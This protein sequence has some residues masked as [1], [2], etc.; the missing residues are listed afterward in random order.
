MNQSSL[1]TTPKKRRNCQRNDENDSG[2]TPRLHCPYT[3]GHSRRKLPFGSYLVLEASSRES[4]YMDPFLVVPLTSTTP[5]FIPQTPS[6]HPHHPRPAPATVLRITYP[7]SHHLHSSAPSSK[8]RHPAP[9]VQ[10]AKYKSAGRTMDL[11]KKGGGRFHSEQ[12][13]VTGLL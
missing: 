10:C 4:L 6:V 11:S 7:I 2:P 1:D 9:S 5:I 3:D 12:A 13:G 8:Y